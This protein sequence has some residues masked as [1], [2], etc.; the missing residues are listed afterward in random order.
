MFD[1]RL[2][3]A[4][5]LAFVA[6]ASCGS[7]GGRMG[8]APSSSAPSRA[9]TMWVAVLDVAGDPNELDAETQELMDLV[10][11]A[12]IVSPGGC[13]GGLPSH[14]AGAGDYVLG[15]WADSEAELEEVVEAAG[16]TPL[17]SVEVQD[18]CP[19]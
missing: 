18:L 17:I 11:K 5:L 16:R 2:G 15:V 14:V 6:A 10:G 7:T 4:A 19:I 12:V 9:R 13:L 8:E 1:K 3:L